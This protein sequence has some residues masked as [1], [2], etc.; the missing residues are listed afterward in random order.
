MKPYTGPS[1]PGVDTSTLEGKVMCG[2]Q[3][4]FTCEGDGSGIPWNHYNINKRFE[5][6]ACHIDF[7]PDVAELGQDEKYP[8]PFRH[9]DGSVAYVFSS[10]NPKTVQRHFEWMRN[11]GIDGAFVQRFASNTANEASYNRLNVVLA[12]C[13]EAANRVGRAYVVMYD[14]SGMKPGQIQRVIDDWKSLVDKMRIG[15]D[16]NDHAY[17]RHKGKPVVAAWG[18][19][20]KDR[21]TTMPEWAQFIDFLKNDATY[22][23]FTVMLG[24]PTGWRTLDRDCLDDPAFSTNVAEAD[25]ISPWTVGRYRTPE[26]AAE[27][28]KT[29]WAP[30][31]EWRRRNG[32]DYLPVVFPGFSW[33]NMKDG[34]LDAIPRLKG[35]F[36]WKQCVEAKRAGA[37]M[38]YVAMFDE[39]DE[40]TAIFKCAN[41]PP[42]GATSFL[43]FEGLP[44]DYYLRLAGQAGRLL[45]GEIPATEQIP[46]N[47]AR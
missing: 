4:L 18:M 15:R 34:P 26:A 2:Y 19:G 27:H 43:T 22:G 7:W 33:H 5:P 46:Q 36:F 37:T 28:A 11:A 23:G 8:T 47:A 25:I 42:V 16:A 9:A 20:F 44:S 24:V 14:L 21:L 30:D 6:G 10:Y 3:G 38:L 12:N 39:M 41:N 32:K 35:R 1:V 17:L 31:I 29:R 45:R 13:R 40:G